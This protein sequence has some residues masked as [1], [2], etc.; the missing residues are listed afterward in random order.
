ME[1]SDRGRRYQEGGVADCRGIPEG[2][3]AIG[4]T[5]RVLP[6]PAPHQLYRVTFRTWCEFQLVRIMRA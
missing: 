3:C 5:A 6:Q 2:D 4:T 1:K